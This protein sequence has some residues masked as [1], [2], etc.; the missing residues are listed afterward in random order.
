M[1]LKIAEEL[2]GYAH[3]QIGQCECLRGRQ[4]ADIGEPVA[5][6]ARGC[7]IP[8]RAYASHYDLSDNK[9]FIW[10]TR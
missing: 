1:K 10:I 4:A 2:S 6:L 3:R 9:C 7:G 8:G 5:Q